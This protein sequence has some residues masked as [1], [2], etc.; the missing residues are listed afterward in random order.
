[1][2]LPIQKLCVFYYDWQETNMK[3]NFSCIFQF[4][5]VLTLRT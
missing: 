1:M 3:E 5:Q 4:I 2:A